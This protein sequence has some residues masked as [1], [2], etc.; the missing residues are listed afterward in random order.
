MLGVPISGCPYIEDRLYRV[1]KKFWSTK[2][3]FK[4]PLYFQSIWH[5]VIYHF[6]AHSVHFHLV[7]NLPIWPYKIFDNSHDV[8]NHLMWNLVFPLYGKVGVWRCFK[9]FGAEIF[10]PRGFSGTGNTIPGSIFDYRT[11]YHA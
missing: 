4:F 11:P 8:Y 10:S 5:C 9:G 7:Y 3:N 1:R 2:F 6:K